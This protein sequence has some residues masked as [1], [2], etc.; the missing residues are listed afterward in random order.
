MK[1]FRKDEPI[2]VR[3]A[4]E[5]ELCLPALGAA[6]YEWQVME[7]AAGVTALGP[8]PGSDREEDREGIG[9][10]FPQRLRFRADRPGRFNVHLVCQRAFGDDATPIE[11]LALEI[12]VQGHG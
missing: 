3:V 4:E 6:G 9:G 12:T 1:T 11:D 7:A 2:V 8:A 10:E 5:F